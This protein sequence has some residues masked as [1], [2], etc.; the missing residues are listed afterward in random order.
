MCTQ[1]CPTLGDPMDCRPPGSSIHGIFQARILE[2]IVTSFSR[3]SSQPRDQ[4][5]VSCLSFIDRHSLPTEP[6]GE[7]HYHLRDEETKD[8]KFPSLGNYQSQAHVK[9]TCQSLGTCQSQGI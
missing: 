5:R 2:W 8:R 6:L 4:T 1:L 9:A 3:G 7:A